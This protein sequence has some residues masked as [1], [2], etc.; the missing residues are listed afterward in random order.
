MPTSTTTL[1]IDNKLRERIKKLADSRDRSPHY[2]MLAAITEYIER[3][4]AQ[5]SFKQEALDSWREYQETGLHLTG[6]E[7]KTWLRGWGT[8]AET[9]IP[10]CHK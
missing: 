1:K 5:E 8:E 6:D 9:D 4:E 7:V 3:E 10:E 2:L